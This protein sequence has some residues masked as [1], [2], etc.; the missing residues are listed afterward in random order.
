MTKTTK[1]TVSGSA[2]ADQP[3]LSQQQLEKTV[4]AENSERS[5]FHGTRTIRS[6][7]KPHFSH[8]KRARNGAP[9]FYSVN[10]EVS[11]GLAHH[12]LRTVCAAARVDRSEEHTSELQS[13]RHL[14]C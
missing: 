13:L 2:S 6:G 3:P 8:K 7:Q 9:G 5:S 4:D 12:G 14:V 10:R 11:G 1:E